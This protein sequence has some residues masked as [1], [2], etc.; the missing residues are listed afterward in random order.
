MAFLQLPR[1]T[2]YYDLFAQN[3]TPARQEVVLLLHGFAGT[4]ESDFA[5]QIPLLQEQYTVLAPHLH[6]HGQSSHRVTYTTAYYREDVGDIVALL[7][8]LAL[9]A[10]RVLG[11]SDGAITGLLLAALH[12][13]RVTALAIHG[14][15]ATIN[16]RDTAAIRHW[17]LERPLSDEWQAQLAQLHG[18]PYW[19][20]LPPMYV[21]VQEE[22]V[23]EGGVIITDEELA[24]IRCPVLVMHGK[25]DRIVSVEYA[26]RL[27]ERIPGARLLLFDAGHAAH[28]RYKDEYNTAIMGFFSSV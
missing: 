21:K 18:E 26:H 16:A 4:S 10:V 12:P 19:R 1:T 25:R 23:A 9:P 14:A 11:F 24:A 8:A 7:D 6:G 20:A 2:L 22:L 15:Q 27:A 28:L 3:I 5:E 13:E 17:L